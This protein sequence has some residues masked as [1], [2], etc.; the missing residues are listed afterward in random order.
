[1]AAFVRG[2]VLRCVR[3]FTNPDLL[4][5]GDIAIV[6]SSGDDGCV[7]ILNLMRGAGDYG[8]APASFK[9]VGRNIQPQM[10]GIFP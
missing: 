6:L 5:R 8:Y 4:C 3:S 1:M 2:D 7:Q 9:K 10:I